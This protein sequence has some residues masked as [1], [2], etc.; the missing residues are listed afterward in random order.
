[1]DS[2]INWGNM[3]FLEKRAQKGSLDEVKFVISSEDDFFWAMDIVER[4]RLDSLLP[5]LFSPNA[6]RIEA[7]ELAEMILDNKLRVRLQLQLHRIL[8][9]HQDRGV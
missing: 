8:W 4:Y 1:M 6:D 9:P 7:V 2:T 5:V 3:A